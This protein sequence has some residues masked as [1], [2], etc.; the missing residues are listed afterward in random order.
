MANQ[1]ELTIQD[2]GLTMRL[3]FLAVSLVVFVLSMGTGFSQTFTGTI[4]GY[5]SYNFNKATVGGDRVNNFRAFDFRAETFSLNYGELAVDYKPDNVGIH[6][7]FG[8]GDAANAVH[9]AEPAGQ[10]LWRHIQQAYVTGTT[11]NFTVDFG[12]FV[13]PIGAEVIETKDNWNYSRGLLFTLAI[14]FYHFGGR[15]TYAVNDKVSLA[16]Y[17]VNGWDNVKDNNTAKSVGFVGTFKPSSK[18]TLVTNVLVGKEGTPSLSDETRMLFDGILTFNLNDDIAF[19]ANYDFGKDYASDILPGVRG[20]EQNWQGV[21]GYA[22]VKLGEKVTL[23]NRYEWFDDRQGFRTATPQ[24]LQSYTATVMI[25][26]E[27]ATFWGEYRRDWSNMDTFNTSSSGIFGPIQGIRAYQNTITL[28]LT[29]GF[30][31]EVN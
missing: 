24:E 23:S 7:D 21:A 31:K 4:D 22:K 27:G 14:P 17:V 8:F 25:P 15:A 1:T 30:T 11:G 10:N 6:V 16:G 29:Y 13:T 2:G 3:R 28:G 19:M 9:A 5:W 26:W 12:K 18:F 20:A